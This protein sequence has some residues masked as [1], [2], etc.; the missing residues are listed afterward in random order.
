MTETT[1][2]RRADGD[3]FARTLERGRRVL[4]TAYGGIGDAILWAVPILALARNFPG[5]VIVPA[6]PMLEALQ[7]LEIP[8]TSGLVATKLRRLVGLDGGAIDQIVRRWRIGAVLDLRRDRVSRP[9]AFQHM[10]RLL[11]ER[12]IAHFDACHGVAPEVQSSIHVVDLHRQLFE[13]LGLTPAG[14][15]PGWLMLP[16]AP[17]AKPAIGLF[18]GS[19]APHKRLPL[20][21]WRAAATTLAAI[22]PV[23]IFAGCSPEERRDATELSTTLATSH[24]RHDLAPPMPL[25]ELIRSLAGLRGLVSGDTFA[26]HA[27][28]AIG[29]RVFGV[30]VAT[31]PRV[32]GPFVAS[33]R[34][35]L[36]P[37]YASCDKLSSIGNCHAW[38]LPCPQR[39][40]V[41]ALDQHQV[42][43]DIRTFF[44]A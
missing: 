1:R 33:N 22:A 15:D 8:G 35:A 21:F 10:T 7:R 40:C 2:P 6:T 28:E 32:Y 11:A 18:L 9:K 19:G 25:D 5:Q 27:A 39:A 16:S 17:A 14:P 29:L 43:D 41:D 26:V 4:V 36:S 30:Y 44:H 37:G 38:E 20:A 24:V 34:Y 23:N 13:R 12:G 3:V 31:D 42:V